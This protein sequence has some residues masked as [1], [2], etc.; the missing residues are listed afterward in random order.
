MDIGQYPSNSHKSKEEQKKQEEKSVGQI[1]K[2]P[3]KRRRQGDLE[4][5]ARSIVAEDARTVRTNI[6]TNVLIPG[7]KELLYD[8]V[9]KG[10]RIVFYGEDG[11]KDVRSGNSSKVSYRSYYDAHRSE[12]PREN[13]IDYREPRTAVGY[14]Y[15][16]IIIASKGEAEDVLTRMDEMIDTYGAVSVADFYEMVGITGEY[17][18]N[19]Y[20]WTDLRSAYVSRTRDGFIIRFP[21]SIALK[22]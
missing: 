13:K 21:P 1:V 22:K 11:S 3:A 7:F 9:T 20:G 2:T 15:D 4:K 5:F 17:T 8:I 12:R 10:A 19:N 18:D 16:N 6:V 14:D